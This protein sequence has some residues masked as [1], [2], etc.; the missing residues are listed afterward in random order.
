MI[1]AAGSVIV[2]KSIIGNVGHI[3]GIVVAKG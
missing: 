3:E 1:V 2:E